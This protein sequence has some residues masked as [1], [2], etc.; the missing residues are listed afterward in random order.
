MPFRLLDLPEHAGSV[1]KEEDAAV[2]APVQAQLSPAG[3]SGKPA[4]G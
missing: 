4:W 3:V 2:P 1:C